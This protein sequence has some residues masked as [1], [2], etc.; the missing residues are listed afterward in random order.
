[1]P[2]ME[3]WRVCGGKK[4]FE[5]AAYHGKGWLFNHEKGVIIS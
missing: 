3:L 4:T 2:L 5:D 1:M